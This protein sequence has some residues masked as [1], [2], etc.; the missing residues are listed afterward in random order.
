MAFPQSL[1]ALLRPAAF[2]FLL[3][4]GAV[5]AGADPMIEAYLDRYCLSCHDADTQKGK[6]NLEEFHRQ[7]DLRELFDVHDQTVLEAMPPEKKKQPTPEE[8]AAFLARLE[9]WLAEA[10]HDRKTQPG[11]GNL[12]DHDALFTPNY[13][14][15]ASPKRVWRV[16][17]SAMAEIGN[18]LAG[19]TVYRAKGQGVTKEDPSFTYR[20]PGHAFRD[21]DATSYFED[22]TTE[23]VL[24]YA[25]QIAG[26]MEE[27]R[28]GPQQKQFDEAA[29]L[30]NKAQRA[31]RMKAIGPL[32][33]VGTTFRLLFNREIPDAEREALGKLDE[34]SAV[35]ALILKCE[36]VFRLEGEMDDH[37]LARTLGF[38]LAEDGPDPALYEAVASRPLAGVLDE[39]MQTDAFNRRLVRFLREYFE[40]D[41]APDVFKDPEDQPPVEFPHGIQYRPD[42][43]VADADAFCL[44]IVGE[45]EHVL[46]Q[47]LTSNRYSIRGGFNTTHIRILKRAERNGYYAGFHGLYGLKPEELEPWRADYDVPHRKGLLMHPAWL[48]AF[49]DNEKNQAIQR[50]RWVTTKL[51][52]GQI[53][54]TP[55]EVDAT[56]PDDPA[57]TLREK[58]AKVTRESKCWACHRHM[59]D[60]GLPFEQFDFFGKF[61]TEELGRPVDTT[62]F[63]LGNKV[64]DPFT[65][66]EQLA[67]SRRVQQVFLRHAFRFFMGR[68][69]TLNDANTL[70]AMDRAYQP[71]GSLK[72]ALKVLFL[73]KNFRLRR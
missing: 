19:R 14:E 7:R 34:A 17:A 11:F 30:S 65:Y 16:D 43:H 20:A 41:R 28:F 69:E 56:L 4:T 9:Q 15:P 18:R 5:Q 31:A 59:D 29:K 24:A 35:T 3:T 21:Y 12:V 66:V 62:G 44:R 40:Y 36:S 60:Q 61:R 73:S 50:G 68:N 39:R 26:Y 47:L 37:Q 57:L 55:V 6:V 42:W 45:D 51:L 23:L 52:G 54:D 2:P 70:I 22:T 1:S 38:A 63:V 53:P 72:A 64:E 67:A 13:L 49:S 48:I 46:R 71:D 33:R 27:F 32:D 10:G 25:K 8:R 58:M